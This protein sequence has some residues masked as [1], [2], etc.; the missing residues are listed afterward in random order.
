MFIGTPTPSTHYGRVYSEPG[1]IAGHHIVYAVTQDEE[2]VVRAVPLQHYPEG[3]RDSVFDVSDFVDLTD[4]RV[5]LEPWLPGLGISVGLDQER[6]EHMRFD[7]SR[8]LNAH[9]TC[10]IRQVLLWSGQMPSTFIPAVP[11]PL[12]A[13]RIYGGITHPFVEVMN[14]HPT[15]KAMDID[16]ATRIH[17]LYWTTNG[18]CIYKGGAEFLPPPTP[19]GSEACSLYSLARSVFSS[20]AE[21]GNYTTVF[22]SQCVDQVR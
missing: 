10:P 6:L 17:T 4:S 21:Y 14:V 3:S 12:R 18:F 20:A 22:A 15:T 11:N 19:A 2:L 7:R 13:A 9:W 5:V 1:E 16:Y 8:E